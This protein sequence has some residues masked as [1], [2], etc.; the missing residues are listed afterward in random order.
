[1]ASCGGLYVWYK[2][3]S[4]WRWADAIGPGLVLAQ[5]VGRWGNFFNQEAYGSAAP[6]WLVN[7][8]PGWLREGM[9]IQGTVMQPTFLYESLWNVLVF[10]VLFAVER[11]KPAI[12]VVF[13]LYLIGY[14]LGRFAI[15]SIRQDATVYFGMPMAQWMSLAQIAAG[16][17]FLVW[18]LRRGRHESQLQ[19]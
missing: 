10:A 16:A 9:T 18:H 5:G 7:A 8:M 12:G 17:F 11:R 4:F 6:E 19:A 14:N 3:Q 1:G 13:S 15:E 2:K